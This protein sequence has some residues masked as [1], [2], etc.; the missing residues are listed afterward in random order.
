[1][2]KWAVVDRHGDLL[3]E[4]DDAQRAA[5][6]ATDNLAGQQDD[7]WTNPERPDSNGWDIEM[8]DGA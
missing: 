4:F 6:W 8:R 1:M 7:S 5:R 2:K 3:R